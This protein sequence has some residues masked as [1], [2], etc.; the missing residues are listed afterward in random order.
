MVKP[1][2]IIWK[3]L[4][5]ERK[6]TFGYDPFQR[7][8]KHLILLPPSQDPRQLEQPVA[9]TR[10]AKPKTDETSQI[11]SFTFNPSPKKED[12]I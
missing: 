4:H 8:T 7:Y 10:T 11:S 1:I 5:E 12:L 3:T 6:V 9:P 2:S